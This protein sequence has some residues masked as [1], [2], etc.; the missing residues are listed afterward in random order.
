MAKKT[1]L[2]TSTPPKA[3]TSVSNL[4]ALA[5][6]SLLVLALLG[7]IGLRLARYGYD[8][9]LFL[10]KRILNSLYYQTNPDYSRSL[11]WG[12]RNAPHPPSF[13]FPVKKGENVFRI[14]V[15]GESSVA[16][17]PYKPNSSF[18]AY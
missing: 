16:G 2:A 18:S 3:W 13:L 12:L 8:T 11:F 9:H 1:D 17:W 6:L 5:V 10:K 7:E 14:F 4:F 15:V